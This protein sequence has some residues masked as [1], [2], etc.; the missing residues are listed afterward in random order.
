MALTL[1]VHGPLQYTAVV[2]GVARSVVSPISI[3][4]SKE[5]KMIKIIM[6]MSH[7]SF[8]EESLSTMKRDGSSISSL[9][10]ICLQFG[11]FCLT[12]RVPK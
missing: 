6:R 7:A 10:E 4:F 8:P 3:G 5:V 11:G 2:G 1:C 9:A 12:T